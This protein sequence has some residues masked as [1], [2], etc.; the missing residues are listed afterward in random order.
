MAKKKVEE[1]KTEGLDFKS[2]TKKLQTFNPDAQL[3]SES[4]NTKIENFIP[5]GNYMLNA[6][7]SGDIYGGIPEGRITIFA[8]EQGSGKTLI[9]LST[10]REAQKMGYNIIWIDTE[11]ALDSETTSRFGINSEKFQHAPMNNISEVSTYLKNLLDVMLENKEN[12][13]ANPKIMIVLDSLGNLSTSK[14]LEDVKTGS[15]KAD[16]TRAKEIRRLFRVLTKDIGLLKIPVIITNHVYAKIDFIGGNEMGG[17]GGAKFNASVILFF[18]KAQL[19]EKQDGPKV[20]IIVTSTPYKNRFTKPLKIQFYVN[21]YTGL[22]PFVGLQEF[23]GWDVC[24]IDYGKIEKGNFVPSA[25]ATNIAVQHL[26]KTLPA[27]Q[28]YTPTVIT[29][30]VL[31]TLRPIIKDYFAFPDVTDQLY[32]IEDM[33]GVED[34][35]PE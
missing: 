35:F 3:L 28:L 17:G 32:N 33:L 7:I 30:E 11:N 5:T 29:K 15:E 22:N 2:L 14:E 13:L 19:K 9:A 25:K 18:T 6:Q 23:I 24:G 26:G 8:G 20:G 12:K 34:E 1:Q 4:F 10:C 31:D 21:F 27:K 16:M